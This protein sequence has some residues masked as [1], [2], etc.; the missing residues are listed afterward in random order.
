MSLDAF[1]TAGPAFFRDAKCRGLDTAIFYPELFTRE[2]CKEAKEI[3][4]ECPAKV[5]CLQWALDNEESDGIYGGYSPKERHKLIVRGV[6]VPN[7]QLKYCPKRHPLTPE[8]SRK[9]QGIVICRICA[10][11]RR[12]FRSKYRS[13]PNRS[14]NAA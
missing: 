3:C 14:S 2:T 6:L 11:R 9:L 5:E 10:R 13:R 12:A 4:Q 7:V 1:E 8:N